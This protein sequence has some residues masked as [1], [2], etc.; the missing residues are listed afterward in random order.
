MIKVKASMKLKK[1]QELPTNV[2]IDVP[3]EYCNRKDWN[4][5]IEEVLVAMCKDRIKTTFEIME[6]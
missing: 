2:E 4:E 6:N 1:G 3:K 5:Y